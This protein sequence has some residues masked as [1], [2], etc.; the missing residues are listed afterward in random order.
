L[1]EARK[2]NPGVTVDDVWNPLQKI[3]RR[4]IEP[5]TNL[6]VLDLNGISKDEARTIIE[7]WAGSGMVR[8]R[9]EDGFVSETWTMSGG[10]IVGQLERA[11][12]NTRF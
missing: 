11:V 6:E 4:A 12:V 3:D 10:G 1:A 7:F 2:H 5:L 9:I 8:K